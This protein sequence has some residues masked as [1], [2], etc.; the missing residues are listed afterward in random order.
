MKQI[1]GAAAMALAAVSFSTSAHAQVAPTVLITV[2]ENGNGTAFDGTATISVPGSVLANSTGGPTTALTYTLPAGNIVQ[3]DVII[4]EDSD[5]TSD[6]IRFFQAPGTV[7]MPVQLLFF[8]DQSGEGDDN[9]LADTGLP[10]FGTNAVRIFEVG[11]EGD[12]GAFYTPTENQP[13]FVLGQPFT[14]HFISDS[15]VPEPATWAMMIAGFGAMGFA[16]RRQRKLF[17]TA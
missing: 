10:P 16:L 3:G 4:L 1:M 5:H 13:G 9:G 12:N 6:V 11:P 2:D 8:S 14:Y 7:F 17:A 15:S